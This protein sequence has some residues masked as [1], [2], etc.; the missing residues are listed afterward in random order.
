MG[1]VFL[2]GFLSRIF[3]LEKPSREKTSLEKILSGILLGFLHLG[4]LMKTLCAYVPLS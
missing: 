4:F 1:R 3:P 2:R